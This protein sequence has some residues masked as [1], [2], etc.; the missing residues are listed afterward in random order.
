[1]DVT[2]SGETQGRTQGPKLVELKPLACRSAELV[3]TDYISLLGRLHRGER[4]DMHSPL[5]DFDND[6]P[7]WLHP[8]RL[9]VV[10]ARPGI[11]KTS[12]AQLVTEHTAEHHGS[13]VLFSR[14][15][16]E[17]EVA[18]RSISR[19]SG[20]TMHQLKR[21]DD[22]IMRTAV[23]HLRS[24]SR[25]SLYVDDRSSHVDDICS[26]VR[27]LHARLERS[28]K[29]LR[30]VTLDYLQLVDA[31]GG[32]R[33]EQV[34]AVSRALKRLALDLGIAVLALSQLN[35]DV[36]KRSHNK[37]LLSD[38]RESGAIEQDADIVIGLWRDTGDDGVQTNSTAEIIVLKNRHG[39]RCMT[40]VAWVAHR[41]LFADL[42]HGGGE[43]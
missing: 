15:M 28:E 22:E 36:E 9:I 6:C 23:P 19:R 3:A 31:A 13:A 43:L 2:K 1:M 14:E 10:A 38:L 8:G 25:L 35:R 4:H 41:T 37:P 26:Q 42:A 17:I 32:N 16:S 21:P 40:E 20:Y 30:L 27:E 11:G 18:E 39:P 5:T 12:F 33:A 34:G 24:L 29:P 7:G